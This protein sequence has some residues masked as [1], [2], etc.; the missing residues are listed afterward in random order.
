MAHLD[1]VAV[2]VS[3]VEQGSFAG[4]ASRLHLPATTV[5]RRVR[6]L[7]DRL[8]TRLLNRTTRSLAMTSAGE[9]YFDACRSG[10]SLIEEAERTAQG[11]QA[12]PT[13]V[14]R[15]SAPVNFAASLFGDIT[16]AFMQRYPKVKV[17]LLLTDELVDLVR[18]RI[19]VALRTGELSDSSLVARKLGVV[20]RLYCASPDYVAA[21]GAPSQP[22]DLKDHDCIVSGAS[23]EGV[24]WTFGSGKAAQTIHL[25]ARIAAN[26]MSF[27]TAAAVAGL[28]IAQLPEALAEPHIAAGR[29]VTVLDDY[30]VERGGIYLVFPSN[31]HQ[32]AAVRAF[33]D[34]VEAWGKQRRYTD[35]RPRAPKRLLHG[36][37]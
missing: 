15:I 4:A 2:F 32:S 30:V 28:G 7:E 29:L 11:T 33:V 1:D 18:S 10:L 14:V 3:V 21:R 35:G 12:E 22:R 37:G 17:E 5:S 23:T 36:R 31:R 6:Q 27:C 19:D 13:G 24:T 26:V 34:H 20:R 16:A 9:A 25:N 8:G